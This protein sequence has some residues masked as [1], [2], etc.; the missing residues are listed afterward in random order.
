[1]EVIQ[2]KRLI[3]RPFQISDTEAMMRVF[4]DAE[5]MRFGDGVQTFQWV[6]NWI[7]NCLKKNN[8]KNI[9]PWAVVPKNE[10]D[11]IG[12]CGLFH[13][14]D[15]CGQPETEIG[16]RLAQSYWGQGYATEAVCAVRDYA[17]NVLHIPRLIALIDPQNTASIRVAKKAG[18]Q[19]E[20]E[21]MLEG[22]THPDHVYAITQN[23]K[24]NDE[25]K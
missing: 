3:L 16:Y 4:G 2:T 12:Y 11:P 19:Y 8:S 25:A 15:I 17:F 22:Y 18:M 23:A 1:M 10:T 24:L 13:F 7:A 6:Q 9:G 21:A 20:K 14:P 5:V